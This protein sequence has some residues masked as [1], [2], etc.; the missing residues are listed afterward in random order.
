MSDPCQQ[1]DK[2]V[3]SPVPASTPSKG[4]EG[5]AAPAKKILLVDDNSAIL[6]IL[7]FKLKSAGYQVVT[8]V[9]G[10]QAISTARKE[11]PDLILLDIMFPP[12]VGH[13][14]GVGWDAFVI[15]EW[16]RRD[17]EGRK[18]PIIIMSGADPAIYKDRSLAA[19]AVAFF[20]KPINNLELLEAIHKALT[21][22]RGSKPVRAP[23]VERKTGV[24]TPSEKLQKIFSAVETQVD[25]GGGTDQEKQSTFD[26]L[27]VEFG[28]LMETG[29]TL[30][31]VLERIKA[32]HP[33]KQLQPTAVRDADKKPEADLIGEARDSKI[34]RATPKAQTAKRAP[35]DADSS[36]PVEAPALEVRRRTRTRP[37]SRADARKK[38]T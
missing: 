3:P 36:T 27:M 19:G 11:N 24:E 31:E 5:T 35:A 30:D 23:A 13:G 33:A 25:R 38:L 37:S 34:V 22:S 18:T 1:P 26:R 32:A 2:P 8:A 17:E 20:H 9:D 12:D 6:K 14:G 7:S 29:A 10:S 28:R 4:A 15:M 21:E 16:L